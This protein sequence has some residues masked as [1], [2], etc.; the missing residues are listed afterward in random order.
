[1][2]TLSEQYRHRLGRSAPP[3]EVRSWERSLQ[4]L[5]ADLVEAGL[6]EVEVLVEHQ[7]PLTSKRADV[8]LRGPPAHAN[9]VVCRGRAQ[10]V[11]A[12]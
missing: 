3:A 11:V 12:R 7:L 1:M 4:V 9:P 6:D 5:S 10:A 2:P 8:V